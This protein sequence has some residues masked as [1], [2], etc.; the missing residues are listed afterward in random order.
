VFGGPNNDKLYGDFVVPPSARGSGRRGDRIHG[1]DGN[2]TSI[3]GAGRDRMSGGKG[4]DVQ[5][6][7][8]GRD[9]I[10]ANR[11]VDTSYGGNG[12]DVLWALA[13]GDVTGPGDP[14]GDTLTGGNGNDTFR[15]RDGEVDHITCGN[16]KHDRVFADQYDVIDDATSADPTGSCELVQRKDAT[17]ETAKDEDHTESP[18]DD[19]REK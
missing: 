2:D 17:A 8:G 16:G 11:G 10:F 4:D 1:G 7:G 5:Y 18:K 19:S 15:V 12:N 14:V 13:K 6:G 9:V 3:G